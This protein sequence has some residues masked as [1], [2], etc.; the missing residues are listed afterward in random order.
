MYVAVLQEAAALAH[1]TCVISH[2]NLPG[3]SLVWPGLFDQSGGDDG[4]GAKC[5]LRSMQIAQSCAYESMDRK[6]VEYSK[7]ARNTRKLRQ[8]K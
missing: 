5:R 1:P 4:G 8:T 7:N 3:K 6:V 2:D